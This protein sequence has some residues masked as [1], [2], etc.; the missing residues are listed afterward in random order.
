MLRSITLG[1][2]WTE[3]NL[4]GNV[5]RIR[6][7]VEPDAI[8][9]TPIQAVTVHQVVSL[10]QPLR[11]STPGQERKLRGLLSKVFIH[12]VGL[13]L[14]QIDHTV[15]A[16][17]VLSNTTQAKPRGHFKGVLDVGELRGILLAIKTMTGIASIRHSL[18]LQAATCQRSQE[19]VAA[20]WDEFDLDGDQPEWRIPRHR[21]KTK[22]LGR[23]DHIVPLA[24]QV[25]AWLKSIKPAGATGYL[26]PARRTKARQGE[27]PVPITLDSG[28][29]AMRIGLKLSGRHVPHGW[30]SSLKTLAMS[31][32]AGD[33][34]MFQE[35]WIESVLDHL[36]PDQTQAAYLRGDVGAMGARRVLTWWANQLEF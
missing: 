29:K 31:A 24:P 2:K 28:A 22:T 26:F 4:K 5:L 34:P 21:M 36:P 1:K 12:G 20:S 35:W 14:C 3:R 19:I 9:S 25:A 13:R 32:T 18:L 15:T 27:P 16:N 10:L 8:W 30:R 17:K 11:V 6:K 23:S 7:H 33:V